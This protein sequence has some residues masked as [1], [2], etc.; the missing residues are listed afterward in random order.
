MSHIDPASDCVPVPIRVDDRI[1]LADE[2]PSGYV[3]SLHRDLKNGRPGVRYRVAFG[4]Q[5]MHWAYLTDILTVNGQPTDYALRYPLPAE[6]RQVTDDRA[7]LAR[8]AL[9]QVA[10]FLA[11]QTG[12]DA[13]LTRVP[14]PEVFDPAEEEDL[15]GGLVGI[16]VEMRFR[17]YVLPG[18][19][20]D[21]VALQDAFERWLVREYIG[22]TPA[23]L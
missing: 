20:N 6:P 15:C 23:A 5:R 8:P 1:T 21:P 18:D 7:V 22:C 12:L 3:H 14:V 4:R 10:Y 17:M 2:R 9:D 13:T 11:Q 16:D 19:Q